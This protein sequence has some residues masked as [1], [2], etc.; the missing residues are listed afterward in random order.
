MAIRLRDALEE[1]MGGWK[2]A[3]SEP[4]R[5]VFDNVSLDVRGVL[6]GLNHYPWMPIFPVFK[7]HKTRKVFQADETRERNETNF[8]GVPYEPLLMEAAEQ[9]QPVA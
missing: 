6:A 5:P 4:W 8:I 9:R 1:T 2:Q 3:V 7:D